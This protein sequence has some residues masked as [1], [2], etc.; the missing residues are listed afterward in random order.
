MCEP[1]SIALMVGGAAAQQKAQQ[2]A[3]DQQQQITSAAQ[4]RQADSE[5]RRQTEMMNATTQTQ[6]DPTAN[7]NAA[8]TKLTTS[9]QAALGDPTTLTSAATGSDSARFTEARGQRASGALADGM[10]TA[11]LQAKTDA[12]GKVSSDNA[13]GMQDANT[14][15]GV[16]AGD[17]QRDMAVAQTQASAVQP[18]PWLTLLGGAA[19]SG[20]SAYGK[21]SASAA[22]TASVKQ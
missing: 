5:R 19:Q 16:M 12:V 2:D 20:G 4:Q 9:N 6:G 22:G 10:R 18:D 14:K 17:N 15:V 11:A 13:M 8:A 21:K 1:A 7:L 3:L